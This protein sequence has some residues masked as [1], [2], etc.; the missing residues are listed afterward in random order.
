MSVQGLNRA[1]MWWNHW[2]KTRAGSRADP[3]KNP[4]TSQ[5]GDGAWNKKGWWK[6]QIVIVKVCQKESQKENTEKDQKKKKTKYWESKGERP[7][8]VLKAYP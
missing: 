8:D 2:L 6:L 4:L 3:R 1:E 5:R 7:A